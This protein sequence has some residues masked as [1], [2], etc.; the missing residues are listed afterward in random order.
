[1]IIKLLLEFRVSENELDWKSMWN[2]LLQY[3]GWNELGMFLFHS[4]TEVLS[5][6][7][8]KKIVG[9]LFTIIESNR[10]IEIIENRII[11]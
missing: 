2:N 9:R 10:I 4:Q 8:L 6:K 11:E 3:V 1:M 7:L 5:T